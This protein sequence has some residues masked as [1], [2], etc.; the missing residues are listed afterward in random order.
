MSKLKSGKTIDSWF[1]SYGLQYTQSDVD[2]LKSDLKRE[3]GYDVDAPESMQSM[4]SVAEM[5]KNLAQSA[6]SIITTAATTGKMLV[7]DSV[8]TAR[9]DMCKSCPAYD[10]NKNRCTKCGCY[11]KAKV[12]FVAS[13]CPLN[14]WTE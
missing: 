7:T 11:M 8:K 10:A 1:R 13:K 6:R 9:Y 12:E 3:L 14:K 2:E 5:A 4:P